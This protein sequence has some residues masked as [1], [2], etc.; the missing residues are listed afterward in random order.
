ME[1]KRVEKYLNVEHVKAKL[2]S[3]KEELRKR[4][5]EPVEKIKDDLDN[6]EKAQH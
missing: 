6:E 2:E 3:A 5:E 1:H 4:Y